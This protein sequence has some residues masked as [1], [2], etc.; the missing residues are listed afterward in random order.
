MA[1]ITTLQS[2]NIDNV[3]NM[4]VGIGGVTTAAGRYS[5]DGLI[6]TAA[7]A[8]SDYNW[9]GNA[10]GNGIVVAVATNANQTYA[11]STID[12]INYIART[13]P[14]SG[15]GRG[16]YGCAFG[17]IGD[18]IFVA[19]T[20]TTVTGTQAASSTDGISWTSRT[21]QNGDWRAVCFGNGRFV[22]LSYGQNTCQ[23]S[24]DGTSWAFGG[25]L[26]NVAN[27]VSISYS[28]VG[29]TPTFVAVANGP[30]L[31]NYV[32]A[33]TLAFTTATKRITRVLGDFSIDGYV[34]GQTFA[35]TGSAS[36]DQ[37][38][39]VA[40]VGTTTLDVVEA[41]T[42]E[43]A[44][45]AVVMTP[46]SAYFAYS[47]DG[48]DTWSAA[49]DPPTFS[50]WR[51]VCSNGAGRFVAVSK[52]SDTKAAYST[53]GTN[54]TDSVLPVAAVWNNV[55]FG[56]GLFVASGYAS[57][58]CAT[59]TDGNSWVLRLQASANW[60]SMVWALF[61]FRSGDA[62]TIQ[63]NNTVTVNTDQA[64]F[65][66]SMTI[67]NGTLKI[68]NS[69]TET[70]IRFT[71]G[72]ASGTT[73][74][75]I[76]AAS[77]LAAIEVTG[78]WIVL[79]EVG[80]DTDNQAITVPY[81]N[82]IPCLWVEQTPDG[83]DWEIWLNVTGA[84]GGSTKSYA[85]GILDVST[86][87][88]GKFFTQTVNTSRLNE[89]FSLIN[90]TT[91]IGSRVV[92]VSSVANIYPGASINA[93]GTQFPNNSVIEEVIADGNKLII[94]NA[95]TIASAAVTVTIYNPARV[96][97]TNEVVFGDDVHGNKLA[98]GAHVK[99]P[100]IMIANDTPANVLTT[101]AVIG[102]SIVTS[103][104]ARITLDTC[105]FDDAY[106]NFTQAQTVT[107]TDVGLNYPPLFVEIYSLTVDG[108]GIGMP[109]VRRIYTTLWTFRDVRAAIASTTV[110]VLHMSYVSNST[111]ND[112]AIV[113]QAPN[114]ITAGTLNAPTSMINISYSD[115]VTLT[116]I[117]LFA[118]NATRLY[119][120]GLALMA[121]VT[122]STFTGIEYY[123]GPMLNL[124][125]SS[126]NTFTNLTNSENMFYYSNYYVALTKVTYDPE[127]GAD[128]IGDGT[129]KYY[130]K[131]RSY[132]TRDRVLYTESRLYSATPF[133]GSTYFPD[134]ISAYCNATSSVTFG[135]T[136]RVPMYS[137]EWGSNALEVYRGD[138]PS[139]TPSASNRI[140]G[141][142]TAPVVSIPTVTVWATNGRT[143]TFNADKTITASSGSFITDG[144]AVG[145]KVTALGT[146]GA[147]NN[148]TFTINDVDTLQLTVDEAVTT[149]S[150]YTAN[151]RIIGK[152]IPAV[153]IQQTST[154]AR[155]LKFDNLGYTASVG[156]SMQFT[157]SDSR[158][159]QVGGTSFVTEGY[160]VG[161][162]IRVT[163]TTLNNTSGQFLTVSV[164]S[165]NYLTV[166]D[167]IVN[168]GPFTD[169]ATIAVNK[170]TAAGVS[171]GSFVTD[172]WTVGDILTCTGSTD[173]LNDKNFTV[174]GVTATVMNL[175]ETVTT[176]TAYDT[177][178]AITIYSRKIANA[179]F[180]YANAWPGRSLT[181]QNISVTAS[182]DRILTF[183]VLKT[184]TATGVSP[185]SFIT[186]GWIIGD[187]VRVTGTTLNNSTFTLTAVAAT[188]LTV[189]EMMFDE[190]AY[191][192]GATLTTNKIKALVGSFTTDLWTAG[193]RAIVTGTSDVNDG[194]FTVIGVVALALNVAETLTTQTAYTSGACV[195][196]SK[197]LPHLVVSGGGGN[198]ITYTVTNNRLDRGAGSWIQDGYIV[199]DVVKGSGTV[200]NNK[201]FTIVTVTSATRLTTTEN[202]ASEA[203]STNAVTW[204][205][206]GN[207]PTM[208][209]AAGRT[210]TFKALSLT[211]SGTRTLEFTTSNDRITA[212]SGS[213]ITDGWIMGDR[214]TV[215][216]TTNNNTS[217]NFLTVSAV[218]T[219]Y[220]AFSDNLADEGPLSD[221]ATIQVNKVT[222]STGSF[223]T[224]NYLA[225]DR[226]FITGTTANNG[227]FTIGNV[228]ATVLNF[229]EPLIPD[230]S[231]YAA[232][233]VI[234]AYHA[235][236]KAVVTASAGRTLTF[237][238]AKTIVCSTGSFLLD[239]YLTGDVITVA[240]TTSGLNDGKFTIASVTLSTIYVNEPLY[241][242]AA[243]SASVTIT[244]VDL[245]NDNTY[246]YKIRK[247]D[248]YRSYN[249]SAE[250]EVTPT[251]QVANM[252]LCLRGTSF[253]APWSVS[254]LTVGSASRT[255]PFL[256]HAATQTSEALLLTAGGTPGS[257][258]Q[259]VATA[260]GQ[261]YIFSL[262]YCCNP[263][264]AIPTVAGKISL[265]TA[266]QA[267]TAT[268][269]WQQVSVAFTAIASA[270]DAKITIDTNGQ[271]IVA[272]G[273][274]INKGSTVR[275][276]ILTTS[277]PVINAN[278]VRDISIIRSWCRA[279]GDAPTHSGI[280][281]TLAAAPTGALWDEVY[282]STDPD[283]DP[284]L[285]NC[286]FTTW[287][288]S[289][290][291]LHFSNVSADNIV[292]T[293]TQVGK[294]APASY[295]LAYFAI[296]SSRNKIL[297]LT[298]DLGG[299]YMAGLANFLTQS[300]DT[301]FHN[302]NITNF[303]NYFTGGTTIGLF[304]EANNQYSGVTVQNMILN[305]SDFPHIHIGLN[306]IFKGV[307][308]GNSKPLNAANLNNPPISPAWSLGQT[309]DGVA[310]AYAQV[311]DTIF[312]ELYFTATTGC[313]HIACNASSKT[314]KPYTL[315]GTAY[316]DNSGKLYLQTAGDTVT[317]EWPHKILGVSAFRNLPF[318]LSGLDL[319]NSTDYLEGLKIEY[320]IKTTGDY[321]AFTLV[322]PA[323]LSGLTLPA[324]TVGFYLKIKITA[325]AGMKYT[326]QVKNFVVNEQIRGL[327]SGAT[328]YVDTDFD[329]VTQGTLWLKAPFVGT[330]FPGEAIV[331]HSDGEPRATNVATNTSWALFPS[332]SSYINGLQIYTTVAQTAKYPATVVTVTLA[333]IVPGSVYYIF[334]GDNPL[335]LITTGTASGTPAPNETTIDYTFSIVYTEE[336][337]ITVRV[338]K[339][340]APV[341]YLPYEIGGS[342]TSEGAYVFIAQVLDTVVI[343][344]YPGI[345]SDF[346]VYP[347]IKVIK[348]TG[349]TT[350]YTVQQF[351][352]WLLD[353]FDDLGLTLDDEIP[354]S[355]STPTEYNLINGWFI[356]DPSFKFLTGGAIQT[357]GWTHHP[358]TNPTGIRI[359]TLASITGVDDGDF[360]T[361]VAGAVS[362][363][364]GKLLAY[365]TTDKK[366]WVRAD[367]ADDLFDNTSENITVGG[368]LA[369]AMGGSV[370]KSGENI[371][372][373]IFTL[374]SL[375][376]LT[377]LDV[378]QEDV[379]ITRWWPEFGGHI[380]ILVKV[381]EAGVEIDSGNLTVL[382]RTYGSLYDHFV[383]DATSGR[384]PVPLAAFADG[385]NQ[386]P[387]DDVEDYLGFTFDVGYAAKDLGNDHGPQPYDVVVE[388]NDHTIAEVYEYLK[389]VTRSGSITDLG[390]IAGEYYTAAGDI[391]FDYDNEAVDNFDE[392]A[393][394]RINGTSGAYGYL[395]SL[396]DNGLTG[397]MVLRNV[398][399]T[400]VNDMVITGFTS[401][402]T[403]Q[404]NGAVTTIS[405]QKQAPFG[406]F[407]GGQ[408]FGARGVFLENVADA[409]ANNYQL[410]DSLGIIQIPPPAITISVIS[411]EIGDVVSMFRTTGDNE[412][413]NKTYLTSHASA[414]TSGFTTF[415]TVE[416]IPT[417]TPA[418]GVIR[419]IDTSENSE[420]RYSYDSY[421]GK[422]FSGIVKLFAPFTA[423]LSQDYETGDTAYVPFIDKTAEA[424]VESVDITYAGD[425]NVVTRVRK[426]GIIPFTV[427]GQV[428]STGLTVTAIR[429]DD[430]IVT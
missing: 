416:D 258:T 16:W 391:R 64:K 29:A 143:L 375:V 303:R 266:E 121:A 106:N 17:A 323:V 387:E 254:S 355:A 86:G 374:G 202:H 212:S 263:T 3:N 231:V 67:N 181:F 353:Y 278:E 9:Y 155:T 208:T 314:S 313:L 209:A 58:N 348:H 158:I 306:M 428:V 151:A 89:V 401:G 190:A 61:T 265:G 203:I 139:F 405:P 180:I 319:G 302:W 371:W 142:N 373:N 76:T 176:Q 179:R 229:D 211:A 239:G 103:G 177:D 366:L 399:G 315:T 233:V 148:T 406:T 36:N 291:T 54:W 417:D 247:Y 287:Q 324:A 379:Q 350:V 207:K 344:L 8:P 272:I 30:R 299:A 300:N 214:V 326:S 328:A 83:E 65:W 281:F 262:Y 264:A 95:S 132:Y 279:Y 119:N 376:S 269:L 129:H 392:T 393:H 105:L 197:L 252:N 112:I 298:Y 280:E 99:I 98:V 157:N 419:I 178:P 217:G 223:V 93:S 200:Y 215:F 172:T 193:D 162:K 301:Y 221:T 261:D 404:V 201:C 43:A 153:Q 356:D 297:N 23:Y 145:D 206:T 122:N 230:A 245:A 398:H 169:T 359:L 240:N 107:L 259:S 349:G 342:L 165:A 257:L 5:R 232:T 138:T 352:S 75:T 311:Y 68:T 191:T 384:N 423:G 338:R 91:V 62:L 118:L 37:T 120:V 102:T 53:D 327:V 187:K 47:T 11:N 28:L 152:D 159:T 134:Y 282:C 364:T 296:S 167:T 216:G 63:N 335:D 123:G 35:V 110:G 317:Y 237:T 367:A 414:N 82:H 218:D 309:L 411:L 149:Q 219:L 425:C 90:S 292:N 13:L 146:D 100:N 135:W 340:S 124:Q 71:T 115:N 225:D 234:T 420:K 310:I 137:L 242:Q 80:D 57:T 362:G 6:W 424:D 308:G 238:V 369:G 101:S 394:E 354:M 345:S 382:A 25:N 244:P 56:N 285:N 250:F 117:R 133:L 410:I 409:D 283:F 372:S 154:D 31:V 332:Y 213:F 330:F 92:L 196:C 357:L 125:S 284:D 33:T 246:Y 194:T 52:T 277:A 114:A 243:Y 70:G 60:N 74:S 170:I 241:T 365:N 26:P 79:D 15:A 182:A 41:V 186:D 51:S 38:F 12:G 351:Y 294:G 363:A 24:T 430:T 368:T 174:I 273:A 421:T 305:N 251:E 77:G 270:T 73:A 109:P 388:C 34:V 1:T 222:A 46:S 97:F 236:Q 108:L 189:S 307:S 116:N 370:S 87:Q 228:A 227:W 422:V 378:Y 346:T 415:T 390:G 78:N 160:A 295:A 383:I 104:G 55:C 14:A 377:T 198:T 318:K 347:D 49:A 385:N 136:H 361:A 20:G 325:M 322:T 85:D 337:D 248:G 400:F 412:I 418:S 2:T 175:I 7:T 320:A 130:F 286:I 48:G 88:R 144:F 210:L 260:V 407:A 96:Q 66:A 316:F 395:V 304:V 312:H 150:A 21:Q 50:N 402:A 289:G 341:K 10:Y 253:A 271:A 188:V 163:G 343:D 19:L 18:G 256:S 224:D 427:K 127:T 396:D 166:S 220:L 329:L 22:A 126:N 274:T 81:S 128:M 140:C 267:F 39:T 72:R 45:A 333:N 205:H 161:D 290:N 226:L 389:Y 171:P 185:G 59:S 69:S 293:F 27:W 168:E 141:L 426:K 360:G 199:G 195:T 397:S 339:S 403:A 40:A 204:T 183:S 4:F 334:E 156:R 331:R 321:S 42:T 249:D 380:D 358:T 44:S 94:N 268:G 164:V 276:Y 386:T 84:Y 192:S 235:V 147:L 408:F 381:K 113:V 184:I 413:V 288:G 255:S 336:K 173:T 32:N 275:P 131:S 429:T 111:W